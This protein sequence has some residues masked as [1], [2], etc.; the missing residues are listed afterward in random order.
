MMVEA[1]S[2][3]LWFTLI[4]SDDNLLEEYTSRRVS[5]LYDGLKKYGSQ[6]SVEDVKK[7]YSYTSHFRMTLPPRETVKFIV[8][9]AG[10]EADDDIVDKIWMMYEESTYNVKPHLNPESII[11]LDYLKERGYRMS[12]ISNT[13]FSEEGLR[14]ILKNIGL[15]T[16]FEVVIASS[17]EGVEKPFPR[18]FDISADRLKV[19]KA[20]IIHIGDKYIDDVI[21][22]YLAGLKGVLYRGL[23][24][25]YKVYREFRKEELIE[26]CPRKCMILDDL[27]MIKKIL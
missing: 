21:G 5:A 10:L 9:A 26:F 16:Y 4:W 12:I 18:I 3:D 19:D 15:D 8:Y 14:R 11:S 23:W 7:L 17:S 27:R 22:A 20:K 24:D 2:F 25:K 13:S 6:I 1:V